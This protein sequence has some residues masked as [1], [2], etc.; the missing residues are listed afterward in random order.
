M[1]S[2]CWR[3]TDR[4]VV[5]DKLRQTAAAELVEGDY[6]LIAISLKRTRE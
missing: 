4:V 2:R 3:A 5:R 1:V 6:R